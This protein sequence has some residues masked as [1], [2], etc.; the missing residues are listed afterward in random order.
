MKVEIFIVLAVSLIVWIGLF[1]YMARLDARI[2]NLE[3]RE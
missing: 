3:E 2:R 1:A